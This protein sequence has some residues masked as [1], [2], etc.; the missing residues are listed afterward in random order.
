MI[1]YAPDAASI[2]AR[3]N[4]I[5]SSSGWKR[6]RIIEIASIAYMNVLRMLI[7]STMNDSKNE[8][9]VY[10]KK[11]AIYPSPTNLFNM[12]RILIR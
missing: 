8:N 7:N 12:S 11:D 5:A 2:E 1:F 10:V 3:A 4:V 6:A 9:A